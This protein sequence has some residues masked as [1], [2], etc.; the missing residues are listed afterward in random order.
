[1]GKQIQKKNK[2]DLEKQFLSTEKDLEPKLNK[3][4][5]KRFYKIIE[6]SIKEKKDIELRNF[7]I[8]KIKKMK[9]RIGSNPK[10]QEK[11][12]IP[13]KF[14]LSFKPSKI[15]LNKINE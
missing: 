15:L 4:L 1:M 13:E 14:K 11:I 3:E 7:G 8:F 6:G 5:F 9:S 12:Y 2:S 10:N